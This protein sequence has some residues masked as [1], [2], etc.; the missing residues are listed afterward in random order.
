MNNY[1]KPSYLK[2]YQFEVIKEMPWSDSYVIEINGKDFHG[3]KVVGRDEVLGKKTI[4]WDGPD[5]EKELI[6][7]LK[8]KKS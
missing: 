4:H 2:G 8:A 7:N 1:T 6:A 3:R 5:L